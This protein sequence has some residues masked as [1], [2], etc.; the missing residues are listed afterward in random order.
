MRRISS[1]LKESITRLRLVGKSIPEIVS[2][3]GVA[4]TTVQRYVLDVEVPE[5]YRKALKEKQGGAKDRAAA[6]RENTLSLAGSQ[7]KNLSQRDYLL[8]LIGIYWG[9]GTKRDFGII[10]SDPKMIQAF[11]LCLRH[12]GID[13]RRLSLSL[14]VHSDISVNEA[15]KFWA[16]ITG[17]PVN[18]TTRVEIIEG[19]KKGKLP[20][21]MCR[22]RVLSGISERLLVQSMISI[23]GNEADKELLSSKALVV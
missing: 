2:L 3:T 15:K 11:I 22:V 7:L 1:D 12:I 19:K 21:G 13:K 16:K 4:K 17:I 10:N 9:E 5:Q 18:E 23:I 8:L 14:R 6:L 20:Y